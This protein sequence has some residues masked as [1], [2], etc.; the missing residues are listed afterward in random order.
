[1]I[2]KDFVVLNNI[3]FYWLFSYNW[4]YFLNLKSLIMKKIYDYYSGAS[5]SI[6][7]VYVIIFCLDDYLDLNFLK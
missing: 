1:M 2:I 6:T 4:L 5:F 3:I 7:M